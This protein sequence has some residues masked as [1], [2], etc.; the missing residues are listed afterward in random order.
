MGGSGPVDDLKAITAGN[1][2]NLRTKAG[3]TQ[4]ELAEKLNYSD[5][6]VSKWERAEALP[7]AYVLKKLSEIFGVTVD[8]LLTSHDG[9]PPVVTNDDL[10][11]RTK[12]ITKIAI[13]GIWTLATL[14]FIILWLL[15]DFR[16]IIFVYAIPVSLITLL[17]LN[18]IWEKGRNNYYI[19]AALIEGIITSIYLTFLEKNWWQIFILIIPAWIVVFL[20]SRLHKRKK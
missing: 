3:M 10:R 7:D 6:S 14:I 16:W 5:K 12:T 9:W 20:C 18:S 11:H 8:Y 4:L 15:G 19:I 1:I 13:V 17:V 2:I